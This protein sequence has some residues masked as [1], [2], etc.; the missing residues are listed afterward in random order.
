MTMRW[1]ASKCGELGD[2]AFGVADMPIALD[3]IDNAMGQTASD[4]NKLLS[5]DTMMSV[6]EPLYNGE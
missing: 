3:L 6:F 1:L 4:S 5:D 2:Y